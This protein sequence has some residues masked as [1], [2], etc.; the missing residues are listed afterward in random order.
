MGPGPGG[1]EAVG[2][3]RPRRPRA[4]TPAGLRGRPCQRGASPR[5]GGYLPGQGPESGMWTDN[6]LQS[7]D[8][9]FPEPKPVTPRPRLRLA[10]TI[11]ATAAGFVLAALT[12][13]MFVLL[14]DFA[15]EDLPDM[16]TEPAGHLT[17]VWPDQQIA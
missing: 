8:Y 1:M 13:T 3:T 10:M 6:H 9:G 2:W 4:R 15:I 14:T 7:E 12:A 17:S 16:M 5:T 11:T